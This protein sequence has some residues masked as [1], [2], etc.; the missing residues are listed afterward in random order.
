MGSRP[1][2]L[3]T[4]LGQALDLVVHIF[5]NTYLHLSDYL[6]LYTIQVAYVYMLLAPS[7]IF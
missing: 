4:Y 3:E 6:A 5:L 7:K 2:K 1:E